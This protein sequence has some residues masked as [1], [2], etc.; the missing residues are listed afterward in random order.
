MS[1]FVPCSTASLDNQPFNNFCNTLAYHGN[2]SIKYFI[3]GSEYF[4]GIAHLLLISNYLWKSK[5]WNMKL[6]VFSSEWPNLRFILI[7]PQPCMIYT[8][9]YMQGGAEICQSQERLSKLPT[10]WQLDVEER[11][12]KIYSHNL[13]HLKI[14]A[15]G[16]FLSDN[17]PQ[18]ITSGTCIITSRPPVFQFQGPAL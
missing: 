9:Y 2:N 17:P 10:S 6:W 11:R 12:N 4:N 7:I 1:L 13:L 14:F 16:F 18:N 8:M 5:S 15:F 3:I